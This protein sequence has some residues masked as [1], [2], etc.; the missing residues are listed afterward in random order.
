[1]MEDAQQQ[2]L[3]EPFAT[4]KVL[5]AA[6]DDPVGTPVELGD[7]AGHRVPIG[8]SLHP[9]GVCGAPSHC[10]VSE[11]PVMGA[12]IQHR[13]PD[14][15]SRE[16]SIRRRLPVVPGNLQPAGQRNTRYPENSVSRRNRLI[17]SC[18]A[19]MGRGTELAVASHEH[20]TGR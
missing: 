14:G 8:V 2:N 1:M 16:H 17:A 10:L 13:L 5:G 11:V 12:D 4:A 20:Q 3:V 6:V 18:S 15:A 9:D 7:L 19:D